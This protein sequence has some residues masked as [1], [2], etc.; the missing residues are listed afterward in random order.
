M[1]GSRLDRNILLATPLAAYLAL[2]FVVPLALL[3]VNSLRADGAWSLS[4]YAHYLADPFNL[5]V[6]GNSLKLGLLCTLVCLILGYPAGIA[7]AY[8]RPA[9]Q[10]L[11]LAAM[12]LP[13]CVSVIVKAFGWTILLR[14]NGLVNQLL[15]WLGITTEP[16]RMIFTETG[17]LIGIS[18]I[19]LP[20]MVLPVYIV[21]RQ[22]D[23]R[24]PDAAA[25]LGANGVQRFL[26][27]LFPLSVPGLIAGVALVFSLAVS[28]YVIP[29]LLIGDQHQLLSTQIAK[30]FLFLRNEQMGGVAAVILL[31]I[32]I[33]VVLGSAALA[34]RFRAA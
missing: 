30:Y 5:M 1:T 19:F 25:T 16:I 4:G 28:A 6:V 2:A 14:S 12:F 3:F 24:L 13:L 23:P 11:V 33:I 8:A 27:V 17:L 20:F 29:T 15:L 22:I 7:L 26:K 18:N 32:A 9:I 34:R 10:A 31:L 21:V